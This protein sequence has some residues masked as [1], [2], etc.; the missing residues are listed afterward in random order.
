[1]NIWEQCNARREL[2]KQ[3]KIPKPVKTL[4]AEAW[5]EM[6]FAKTRRPRKK[7]KKP[8]NPFLLQ[9]PRTLQ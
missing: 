7:S 5:P 1:M 2:R 8:V 9:A 6:H 4:Q 3:N